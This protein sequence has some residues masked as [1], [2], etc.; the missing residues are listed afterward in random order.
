MLAAP[1]WAEDSQPPLQAAAQ[2]APEPAASG[3]PDE[4]LIGAYIND[5]QQPDFKSNSYAIDLY[6]WFRW[7]AAD[8]EPY[9]TMEFMNRDAA[10]DSNFREAFYDKPA[11]M[12]DGSL[13]NIIRYR[14][15]FS[16]KFSFDVYPFDTQKL[17]V[18]MEDSI[19]DINRL[20]YVPDGKRNVILDSGIT[21]PGFKVGAPKLHINDNRYPTNFGDLTEP[22]EETY[23]R[24]VLS[25]PVT[26][27]ALAMSIKIFLPII[28][29]VICAAL[30]FFIRPRQVSARIGLG[31]TALLTLVALELSSGTS[32][33]DIDYL[34]MLDKIFL[35]SYLFIIVAIARAVWTSWGGTNTRME[36]TIAGDDRLWFAAV[37]GA[38]LAAILTIGLTTLA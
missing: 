3:Q 10:D 16:T 38:Y 1:A 20:V 7:R 15:Q 9:K 2:T 33:P 6:V 4:V 24:A 26:R 31:I 12:P 30:V 23:S 19:S 18:V 37:L 28:L 11:V 32:L 5:I 8:L 13:Y 25:I 22:D 14:G 36:K 27:P 35:L 29:I 21:L 17:K 34:M